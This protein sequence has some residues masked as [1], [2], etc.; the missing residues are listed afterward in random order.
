MENAYLIAVIFYTILAVLVLCAEFNFVKVYRKK[1]FEKKDSEHNTLVFLLL[2]SEYN[3]KALFL[4]FNKI[5]DQEV[6][7]ARK[8][9]LGSLALAIIGVFGLQIYFAL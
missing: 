1:G 5:P 3:L 2:H 4:A 9:F 8:A 6:E 7:K